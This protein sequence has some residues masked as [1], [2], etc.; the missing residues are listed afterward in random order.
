MRLGVVRTDTGKGYYIIG[1]EAG[2]LVQC[3]GDH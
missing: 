3:K 1:L 2:R